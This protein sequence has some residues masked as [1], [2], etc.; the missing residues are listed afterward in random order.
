MEFHRCPLYK[1]RRQDERQQ[2]TCGRMYLEP[3]NYMQS[4]VASS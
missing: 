4:Q 1:H 3:A 2:L